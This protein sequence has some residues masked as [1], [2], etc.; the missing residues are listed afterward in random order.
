MPSFIEHNDSILTDDK[1]ISES[2]NKYFTSIAD[3][4]LQDRKYIGVKSHMDYLNNPL[5]NSFV[6][7]ECTPL[8][9]ESLIASL[10]KNK[11][12]GPNSIPT[13][14][15]QLLKSDLSIPLSKIYNLSL[16]SGTYPEILKISK[17]V[18][19]F[20]KGSHHLI[21]NYRPISLLSN[22]NKILEKLMCNRT[23]DFL[24]R[25]NCI[26]NLQ[27]GFRKKYSVNHA[28]IKI[29]E[30]IRS[31]LDNK[32]V[33]CGVFIDLQ[34]AFDTVNHSILIDKLSHYGIRG[35]AS[36]WFRSYLSNRKQ[37]VSINGTESDSIPVSHGV[38]QG[39]V[40]GPLLF[41]IYINDLHF[42]IKNSS[43]YHFADD[44]NLL[45]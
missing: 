32:N 33:A 18:P 2:F 41:L 13:S 10:N 8:E 37:F 25:F 26:Y 12:T 20:K 17:T 43:V 6:I 21:S 34:K 27:F 28:L 36:N 1:G 9:V 3:K 14:I 15:L 5:P 23:Y 44:T 11:A 31:A 35:V 40:L 7:R 42:S 22:L 38:P 4:I 30:S 19:I 29:T 16:V 39:S 45:N 24:D